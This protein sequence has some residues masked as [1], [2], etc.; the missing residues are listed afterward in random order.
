M[1]LTA[2][3]HTHILPGIDDGSQSLE[4]SI[5]MIYKE[6]ADA[7]GTIL[8]TPHFHPQKMYPDAFLVRRQEAMEQL[9]QALPKDINISQFILGAEVS[10]CSGMS[11]WEELDLLTLGKTKYI[12]IE[13][14]FYKWSDSTFSEL[15]QMHNERGL[16][17]I[18]AHIE[19]YLPSI[20]AN[21]FIN[22]LSA[23]PVLLQCNCEFLTDKHTQRL[24]LKL[25]KARKVHLLGSD[26]HSPNWRPPNIE[27]ARNVLLHN[28]DNESL[29]FLE[30]SE[31]SILQW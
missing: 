11:K 5:K 19:R 20:S 18:L 14:P 8:L 9:L 16:T 21:R 1:I 24:A 23:L 22:R 4:D 7:V 15:T 10:F 28:L 25:I 6:Q 27:Q 29:S 30:K 31:N 2:D 13:M 17:P 3:F 26:C 12:L